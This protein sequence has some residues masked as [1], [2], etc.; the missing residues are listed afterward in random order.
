MTETT[1]NTETTTRTDNTSCTCQSA[2]C[3][4]GIT[5]PLAI[6]L[7]CP[8]EYR[9]HVCNSCDSSDDPRD[10]TVPTPPV[11]PQPPEEPVDGM[12]PVESLAGEYGR[13]YSLGENSANQLMVVGQWAPNL[14]EHGVPARY[15]G[16]LVKFSHDYRLK[17]EMIITKGPN[18]IRDAA[19]LGPN[20][21]VLCGLDWLAVMDNNLNIIN[22]VKLSSM[23]NITEVACINDEIFCIGST[24]DR[25][26]PCVVMK[27]SAALDKRKQIAFSDGSVRSLK[28][29]P[30]NQIVINSGPS[31]A[32]QLVLLNTELD[33]VKSVSLPGNEAR[34]LRVAANGDIYATNSAYLLRFDHQLNFKAGVT[35]RSGSMQGISAT[36]QGVTLQ[37]T[38]GSPRDIYALEFNRALQLQTVSQI[39]YQKDAPAEEYPNAAGT[40]SN[41]DQ[42]TVG[43]LNDRHLPILL[44]NN[45]TLIDSPENWHVTPPM[46]EH[47][48]TIATYEDDL[49]SVEVKTTDFDINVVEYPLDIEY[50]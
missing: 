9:I 46:T 33:I 36:D 7:A 44:A 48:L 19:M 4:G 14:N 24:T 16:W 21:S 26:S 6:N 30:D 38:S 25:H 10:P 31:D 18:Q 11:D 42:I 17:K 27:F 32:K 45:Q 12:T 5:A 39:T 37:Y 13:F 50:R 43:T 29:T 40:L 41:G 8:G 23:N 49:E 20:R 15:H 1:D 35:V 3:Y 34:H 28:A 2:A 22:S 47:P